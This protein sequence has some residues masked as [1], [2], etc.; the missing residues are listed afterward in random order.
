MIS[1]DINESDK[2]GV[3]TLEGEINIEHA[4]DLKSALVS[5]LGRVDRVMVDLERVTAAGLT[6]LELLCSAHRTALS[7]NKELELGPNVS[8]AFTHAIRDSGYERRQGCEWSS[9]QSCFWGRGKE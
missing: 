5:V 6:C 8:E 2:V 1:L 4:R 9:Q 3:L 7:M